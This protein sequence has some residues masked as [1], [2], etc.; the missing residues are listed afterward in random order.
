MRICHECGKPYQYLSDGFQCSHHI[1]CDCSNTCWECRPYFFFAREWRLG[2][3]LIK[4]MEPTHRP[5]ETYI[6]PT[7][8]IRPAFF[9][10]RS[11]YGDSP[12]QKELDLA[13][14]YRW[15]EQSVTGS[16]LG[17]FHFPH[18]F[19]KGDKWL[20]NCIDIIK[21]DAEN[22]MMTSTSWEA[23]WNK[24]DV[25]KLG[26]S[27]EECLLLIEK[28]QLRHASQYGA[29][30]DPG[31]SFYVELVDRFNIYQ[32]TTRNGKLL[33]PNPEQQDKFAWEKEAVKIMKDDVSTPFLPLLSPCLTTLMSRTPFCVSQFSGQH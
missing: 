3:Q 32:N 1:N 12:G 25:Y 17:L 11:I 4:W 18:P 8:N 5:R 26:I 2:V 28:V 6:Y 23:H 16:N 7:G 31:N 20:N 29:R 33:L 22:T 24:S 9:L 21:D 14:W 13:T 10:K 27:L 30:V 19:N 15:F